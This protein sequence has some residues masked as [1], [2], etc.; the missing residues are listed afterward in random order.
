MARSNDK[1]L[2]GADDRLLKRAQR[3]AAAAQAVEAIDV[4][5]IAAS[6][7]EAGCSGL[8]AATAATVAL[9]A[10]LKSG[11]EGGDQGQARKAAEQGIQS[12]VKKREREEGAEKL[13]AERAAENSQ[14]A[15]A[16]RSEKAAEIDARTNRKVA[17]RAE[18]LHEDAETKKALRE[19]RQ[20]LAQG[21]RDLEQA[22]A[23]IGMNSRGRRAASPS[24]TTD[25]FP[26]AGYPETSASSAT[27]DDPV[28]Q[29]ARKLLSGASRICADLDE[30]NRILRQRSQPP[31]SSS[32]PPPV[33][34]RPSMPSPASRPPA[35][36]GGCLS[37][38]EEDALVARAKELL[39]D[40][41]PE[42]GGRAGGN[43]GPPTPSRRAG[44]PGPLKVSGAVSLEVNKRGS[45]KF[46]F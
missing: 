7:Q 28:L 2:S 3:L 6:Y 13:R 45:G 25:G 9:N 17:E 39:S 42:R 16:A 12:A 37:N 19:E 4:K 31:A 10:A 46:R 32:K 21:R 36:G 40:Y 33:P 1:V 27:C 8:E 38:T 43:S 44:Q 18:R 14:A 24:P 34:S 29:R 5:S 41:T 35:K 30:Q 23:R 20:C 11:L 22:R 26:P 15:Q